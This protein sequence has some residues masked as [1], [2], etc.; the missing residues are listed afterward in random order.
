MIPEFP[1][2]CKVCIYYWKRW[3]VIDKNILLMGG[4]VTCQNRR[5]VAAERG[6][7]LSLQCV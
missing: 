1:M 3:V 5:K 2:F 6:G 4:L 7:R